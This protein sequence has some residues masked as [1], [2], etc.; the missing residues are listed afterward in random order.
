[1]SKYR[2]EYRHFVIASIF[3]NFVK[4][5][6][7]GIFLSGHEEQGEY[8][9]WDSTGKLLIHMW[10]NKNGEVDGQRKEWAWGITVRNNWYDNGK[11]VSKPKGV[12]FK[13]GYILDSEGHYHKD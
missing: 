8:K 5:M 6:S 3:H 9:Q 10:Y 7:T 13:E 11:I 1:M 4:I 12:E 2:P